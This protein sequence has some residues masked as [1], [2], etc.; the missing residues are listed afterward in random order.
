MAQLGTMGRLLLGLAATLTVACSDGSGATGSAD[1]GSGA[2]GGA[3][4][5]PGTSAG[6]ATGGGAGVGTGG[7][8]TVPVCSTAIAGEL[9]AL[10]VPGLA[11]GIIAGGQL[12]CTAVAG[13]ADIEAGRA[14]AP[15]TVFAWASV[16]KTV[17]ATAAMIL[18]DEGAFGLDDDV[19][20]YLPFAVDNPGCG[21]EPITFR[22]LLTHTSSIVDDEDT[23]DSV[24]TAG[25]S[26]IALGDFVQGYLESGGAYYDDANFD[27]ACPGEVVEYSNIAVGLLGHLVERMSGMA[28]DDFCR[29]RIFE[30][31]G[32]SET[33]FHLANLDTA[34]VAMPY[35]GE[36]GS[37][38]A[39]GH[40]GF[41]TFPDGLLRT[42]VPHMARFLAMNAGL[43]EAVGVRVL[44]TDTAE[45]MRRVQFPALDDTQG[46]IWFHGSYGARADLVGHD[47][48]D[49]GTSSLIFFDPADGAGVVLVANGDW[50]DDNDD[51]PEADALFGALFA[52]AAGY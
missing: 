28:F 17:T 51:S 25:D 18:F 5:G 33:S 27:A 39:H 23:Y 48:S 41:P 2:T 40:I 42:S 20:A 21:G 22:Q 11:A 13:D 44:A 3:G 16:S 29:A 9:D 36:V 10:R 47:G 46:L 7:E 19:V 32:M 50:Y 8:G 49:P 38:V 14:V 45:E 30:P 15:D 34:G 4:V 35:D 1:G 6:P 43:G 31:L 26:P 52:E 12:V 24:Y 37:F